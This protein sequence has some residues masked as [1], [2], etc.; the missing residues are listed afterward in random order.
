MWQQWTSAV[1]GLAVVLVPFFGLSAAAF[2]WTLVIL[3]VAIAGLGLWGAGE[4][5]TER[6]RGQMAHRPRHT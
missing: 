4:T 3:G 2:T 5:N 1:L 6:E